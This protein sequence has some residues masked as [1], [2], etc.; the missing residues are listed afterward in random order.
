MAKPVELDDRWL[1]RIAEQV[2]GL[3]Y[4]EVNII[5]HDGRIVQIER[6]ERK[7]YDDVARLPRKEPQKHL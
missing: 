7:R 2:N 4:G 5:I 6:K 1:G 3:E